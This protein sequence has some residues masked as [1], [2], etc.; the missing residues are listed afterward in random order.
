MQS[1]TARTIYCKKEKRNGCKPDAEHKGAQGRDRASALVGHVLAHVAYLHVYD[2]ILMRFFIFPFKFVFIFVPKEK[3]PYLTLNLTMKVQ[4][5][6]VH[7]N[8]RGKKI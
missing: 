8:L 1:T 6:K 2:Y 4:H 7:N 3:I 5:E